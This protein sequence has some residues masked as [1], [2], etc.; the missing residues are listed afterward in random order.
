MQKHGCLLVRG[1]FASSMAEAVIAAMNDLVRDVMTRHGRNYTGCKQLLQE[2]D[3][4]MKTPP[5]DWVE[6]GN[7]PFG[8]M[9]TRGYNQSVG[10]GRVFTGEFL[11]NTHLS[12]VQDDDWKPLPMPTPMFD[13]TLVWGWGD[14]SQFLDKHDDS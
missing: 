5:G 7:Q 13:I 6:R 11:Q 3:L 14:N 8:S 10:T 2:N 4:M 9:K 12:A 1:L